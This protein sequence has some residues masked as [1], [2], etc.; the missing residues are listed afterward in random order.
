MNLIFVFFFVQFVFSKNLRTE[1]S[2]VELE[3]IHITKTGGTS[4][5]NVAKSQGILWGFHKR[6]QLSESFKE[7][8]LISTCNSAEWHWPRDFFNE[9]P[10]LTCTT[11]SKNNCKKK[12]FTVVRH[13]LTRILSEYH[14]EVEY[15]SKLS[16]KQTKQMK[17][18]QQFHQII[19]KLGDPSSPTTL[20]IYLKIKLNSTDILCSHYRPQIDYLNSKM[21]HIIKFENLESEFNSLMVNYNLPIRLTNKTKDQQ[22]KLQ[23]KH[24]TQD[25]WKETKALIY[26]F[27]KD[28]FLLLNY[29]K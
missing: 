13:P 10:Y 27:Y 6:N 18:A 17:D 21:D 29:T 3:F 5:E 19:T 1:D 14:W 12:F 28:D 26:D 15:Y 20:N 2:I 23:F 4:I 11:T 9:D 25:L 16:T 24:T 22:T 7:T 8:S